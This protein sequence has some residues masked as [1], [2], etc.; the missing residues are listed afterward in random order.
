MKHWYSV[1]ITFYDIKDPI[2]TSVLND[3]MRA[4]SEWE[5]MC[6]Y[7]NFYENRHKDSDDLMV[8][9]VTVKKCP[10]ESDVEC[11]SNGI[12]GLTVRLSPKA[13]RILVKE[14]LNTKEC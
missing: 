14:K 7:M 5:C 12:V 11:D 10:N 9:Q 13:Y 4:D 8:L 2:H 1:A 6:F 3:F